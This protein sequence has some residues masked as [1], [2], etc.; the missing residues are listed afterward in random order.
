M[1]T[2]WDE[3]YLPP[4]TPEFICVRVYVSVTVTVKDKLHYSTVK[5]GKHVVFVRLER[6]SSQIC[7]DSQLFFK[8]HT[9]WQQRLD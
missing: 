6:A 1:Q 2:Q 3:T 7:A 8:P 5:Y 4:W 9:M